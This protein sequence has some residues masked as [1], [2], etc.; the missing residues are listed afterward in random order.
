MRFSNLYVAFTAMAA[1]VYG[2]PKDSS[3]DEQRCIK[4]HMPLPWVDYEKQL[5][6]F[7]D[8]STGAW[9]QQIP[10]CIQ[11]EFPSDPTAAVEQYNTFNTALCT[12]WAGPETPMTTVLSADGSATTSTIFPTQ[13][14]QKDRYQSPEFTPRHSVYTSHACL[15]GKQGCH[16]ATIGRKTY[17]V[18]TKSM[19]WEYETG[20][21][22]G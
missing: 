21:Y 8:H 3:P 4:L 7:C 14:Q 2:Q 5:D 9:H 11:E 16:T 15:N 22:E 18:K 20:S 12:G 6:L 1:S 10:E 19:G 17:V 13:S